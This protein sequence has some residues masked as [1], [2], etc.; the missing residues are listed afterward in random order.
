M[1]SSSPAIALRRHPRSFAYV[2]PLP[3]FGFC[4]S[5]IARHS[6]RYIHTLLPCIV[7]TA[8]S[9]TNPASAMRRRT[10]CS[11]VDLWHLIFLVRQASHAMFCFLI[12]GPL[13]GG[14]DP[15]GFEKRDEVAVDDGPGPGAATW[16][17]LGKA[18]NGLE[19]V[20]SD[21]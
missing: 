7:H 21:P 8:I 4:Y 5:P 2:S 3:S 20:R 12:T 18:D 10:I 6:E 9:S 17:I 11:I 14:I 13:G 15:L 16:V 1:E 19:S